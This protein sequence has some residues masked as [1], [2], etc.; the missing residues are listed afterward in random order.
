MVCAC[1]FTCLDIHRNGV[2][3]Y[4]DVRSWVLRFCD[5]G[6]EIGR[7]SPNPRSAKTRVGVESADVDYESPFAIL[8][9]GLDRARQACRRQIAPLINEVDEITKRP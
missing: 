7:I 6:N 8:L 3:A 2:I 4:G 9:L 5:V 1:S